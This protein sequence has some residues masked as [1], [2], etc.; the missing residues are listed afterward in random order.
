MT[1]HEIIVSCLAAIPVAFVIGRYSTKVAF[2][3]AKTE[4]KLSVA[5]FV[6]NGR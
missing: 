6:R 1:T 3:H 5:E 2:F 4:E